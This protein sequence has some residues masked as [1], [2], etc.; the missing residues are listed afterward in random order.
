M[1][2]EGFQQQLRESQNQ[3]RKTESDLVPVDP[4]TD[5]FLPGPPRRPFSK[6]VYDSPAFA[7]D[8][9]PDV[10]KDRRGWKSIIAGDRRE[11]GKEM[12]GRMRA[13]RSVIN[14]GSS[15]LL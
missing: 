12:R 4:S 3:M 15:D 14:T 1:E 7:I 5:T 2:K 13:E 8:P 10:Q 9:P 11:G 6:A